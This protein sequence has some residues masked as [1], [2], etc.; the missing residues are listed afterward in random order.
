[1]AG[2]VKIMENLPGDTVSDLSFCERSPHLLAA[3]SWDNSIRVWEVQP[4]GTQSKNVLVIQEQSKDATLRCSFSRS[5]DLYYGMAHGDIKMVKAG[6]TTGT[7]IGHHV[8][9]VTG[10][11]FNDNKNI[12]V[13]GS[14]DYKLC[15][16]DPKS[17][18]KATNTIDLPEKC[19][20]LDTKG[21][22]IAVAMLDQ[23]GWIDVKN[24]TLQKK[25]SK[26]TTAL[27]SIGVAGNGY[28]AGT[29]DGC[30]E[31]HNGTTYN[32]LNCHRKEQAK[33]VYPS[34]CIAISHEKKGGL[35]AGGDGC[36]QFFNLQTSAVKTVEQSIVPGQM[37]PI[38]A[39]AFAYSN[40]VYAVAIGYDWSKG[41]DE[42]QKGAV[43]P[44]IILKK[45]TSQ[46][47]P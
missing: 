17:P 23:V 18:N 25:K 22:F 40:S 30:V 44:E 16:W 14:T 37:K 12:V 5:S 43:A 24:P 20:S 2:N 9:V 19:V 13:S 33:E 6:E 42:Y 38:T 28:L 36:L 4:N 35:S 46:Q 31:H 34:N 29:V 47:I 26:L 27:T 21:D 10:L 45:C 3:T 11:R 7:L 15:F 41:A 39:A 8:G 32:V 1:M